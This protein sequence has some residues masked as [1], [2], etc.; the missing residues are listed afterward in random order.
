MELF[1]GTSGYS[2]APWK[3]KF[4]PK[5]LPAAQMLHFYAERFRTVEINSTFF[6]LPKTTTLENWASQVGENFRFSFKATKRI[7]HMQPLLDKQEVVTTM[8]DTLGML[9]SRLGPVLFQTPPT[10]KK[11]LP[12]LKAFLESLPKRGRTTFEFRH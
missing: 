9:K 12:R 1:V 7:T 8:L 3:G 5:S 6:A 10:L 2:Y 4:Y 11:D